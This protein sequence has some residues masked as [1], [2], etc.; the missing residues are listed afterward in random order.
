MA[1][2]TTLPAKRA[3][4]DIAKLK[5]LTLRSIVWSTGEE[6]HKQTRFVAR[7]DNASWYLVAEAINISGEEKRWKGAAD[8][9]D[10]YWE[11]RGISQDQIQ[12][13]LER[14]QWLKEHASSRGND[15]PSW[16]V[17]GFILRNEGLFL[18]NKKLLK[19]ALDGP[20]TTS[21]LEQMIHALG[22]GQEL[23]SLP[24]SQSNRKFHPTSA[25]ADRIYGQLGELSRTLEEHAPDFNVRRSAQAIKDLE[26]V[27]SHMDDL[28][29]QEGMHSQSKADYTRLL[30]YL[31]QPATVIVNSRANVTAK[32]RLGTIAVQKQLY[33]D[34]KQMSAYKRRNVLVQSGTYVL[35]DK[36][37]IEYLEG[38]V[39]EAV[40]QRYKLKLEVHEDGYRVAGR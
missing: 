38:L 23:T 12:A 17:M 37:Q 21:R 39:I 6:F 14:Y 25:Y 10:A 35:Y 13:Y 20:I 40:K 24:H 27:L 19:A 36:N 16:R 3:G 32:N 7:I 31:H 5:D 22:S 26:G 11:E 9:F 28:E 33:D 1:Q 2:K 34:L 8:S 29:Q 15:P 18:E 30:P 4:L